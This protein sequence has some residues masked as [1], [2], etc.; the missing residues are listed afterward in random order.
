MFDLRPLPLV[1]PLAAWPVAGPA[2]IRLRPRTATRLP[3][4]VAVVGACAAP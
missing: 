1:L 2:E 3:T 4:G